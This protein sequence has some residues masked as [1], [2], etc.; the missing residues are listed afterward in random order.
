MAQHTSLALASELVG[1][2]V[3][4]ALAPRRRA[5]DALLADSWTFGCR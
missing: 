4:A 1:G 5:I 2:P 3:R